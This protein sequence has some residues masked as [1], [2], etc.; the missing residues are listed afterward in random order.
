MCRNFQELLFLAYNYLK[1]L[2]YKNLWRKIIF[3]EN[4][5]GA[6]NS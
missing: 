2:Q 5:V 1:K 3:L 4:P 6:E